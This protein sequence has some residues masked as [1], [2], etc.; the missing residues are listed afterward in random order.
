MCVLSVLL[1][2]LFAFMFVCLISV[3]VFIRSCCL[4]PFGMFVSF[5][6][7]SSCGLCLFVVLLFIFDLFVFADGMCVHVACS[8]CVC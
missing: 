3:E 6:W 5:V 1:F 2:V 4:V 8:L 7:V